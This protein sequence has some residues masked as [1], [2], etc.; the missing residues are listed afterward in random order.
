[1]TEYTECAFGFSGFF[2]E[3]KRHYTQNLRFS[4]VYV[5]GHV[6][7]KYNSSVAYIHSSSITI[8]S[9]SGSPWIS[10]SLGARQKYTDG[11]DA[12]S[13]HHEQ[14]HLYTGQFRIANAPGTVNPYPGHT[15]CKKRDTTLDE[16]PIH[17]RAP[18][19]LIYTYE[20]FNP[21]ACWHVFGRLEDIV[22][23]WGS[24]HRQGKHATLHTERNKNA[25]K[26]AN[27]PKTPL[28]ILFLNV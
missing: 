7:P 21:P 5:H 8:L 4:L 20:Q 25:S 28:W 12:S 3:F 26:K 18:S 11:W 15:G 2:L 24:P 10:R 16:I 19:T 14:T 23:P 6:S 9:W 1:M 22:E 27:H 17:H 13:G